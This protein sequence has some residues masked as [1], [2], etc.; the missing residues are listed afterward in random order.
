MQKRKNGEGT[1]GNKTI[2][3]NTYR[4]FRNTDGKYFYGKTD[5]EIRE[6]VKAYKKQ[7]DIDKEAVKQTFGD[8][9]LERILSR[10][11]IKQHTIDGYENCIK[12]Q[13]IDNPNHRLADYQLGTITT[14]LIQD[15]YNSM[16]QFYSRSTIQKNYAIVAPCIKYGNK[17]NLFKEQID[18]DEVK[19][20]SEDA[21][22]KKKKEINFLSDEDMEKLYKESKRINISGENTGGALGKPTYGNAANLVVF[23]MYTGLRLNEATDLQ[24]KDIN[25]KDNL[26]TIDST[27]VMLKDRTGKAG[28]KYIHSTS[29]TKTRS[30]YRTIPLNN[31]A[32]EVI[33]IENELNPQHKETDYVFLTANGT[34]FTSRQNINRTIAIMMRRANCSI[35]KCSPH[36]LRHSFGS[37]LIRKGVDIKIVSE[38]LGHK[39]ISVT[40]NTYIHIIEEQR[41]KAVTMLDF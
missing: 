36:E 38:L 3:G 4:F 8:F 13:L 41:A 18:L 5:K 26:M 25:L 37:A 17:K 29:T 30:G 19:L 12:G 1:W 9:V 2:K 21:V 35:E 31:K 22:A 33:N 14:E 34:K 27:S 6:K 39:D 28:T 10:H 7:A 11:D 24:W 40:Y 16:K 32:L 20:P 15:Y 23:I